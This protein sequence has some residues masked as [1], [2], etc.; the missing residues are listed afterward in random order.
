M[1]KSILALC[2]SIL[3]PATAHAR[4]NPILAY[5]HLSPSPYTIPAGVVALGT[6]ISFGVTDFFDIGTNIFLNL[7]RVYNARAKLALVDVDGFALALTGGWQ[8][9]NFKDLKSSNP[10]VTVTS[11]MP[12][13]S[14]GFAFSRTVGLVLSGNTAITSTSL[15]QTGAETSGIVQGVEAEADLSWAYA[16]EKKTLGNAFSTGVSYDFTYKLVGMGLSHHWPSFQLGAHYIP[17]AATGKVQPIIGIG[18][19]V[20][21]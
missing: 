14:T 16:P 17:K 6:T 15:N 11:T 8:R 5:T 7:S 21:L 1:R 18:A 12:G 2:I 9:F 19:S 20:S 3:L 4:E 13:L 10:D